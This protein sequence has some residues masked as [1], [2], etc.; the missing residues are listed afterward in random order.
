MRAAGLEV[1]RGL[2]GMTV[3]PWLRHEL[4]GAF[5]ELV[6]RMAALTEAVA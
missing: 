3:F 4:D 5:V 6:R 1:A 2:E